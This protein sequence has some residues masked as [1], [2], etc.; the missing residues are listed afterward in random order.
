[1]QALAALSARRRAPKRRRR[2]GRPDRSHACASEFGPEPL[3]P[4]IVPTIVF[5]LAFGEP[6]AFHD[7]GGALGGD[8]P[9]YLIFWGSYFKS[10][11]TAT[12]EG[13]L[14]TSL[15]TSLAEQILGS[16]YFSG[17]SEYKGSPGRLYLAG[18]T[19][20]PS[21]NEAVSSTSIYNE[22][23][24][25]F[26]A[27]TIP[28]PDN[29]WPIYAVVTPPGYSDSADSDAGGW[30]QGVPDGFLSQSDVWISTSEPANGQQAAMDQ[31]STELSHELTEADTDPS[32]PAG[33]T[34]AQS[35]GVEVGPGALLPPSDD[36][37]QICDYE[38]EYHTYRLD[39]P[40]GPLVESHWSEALGT[41]IVSDGNSYQFDVSGGFLNK[42]G[43]SYHSTLT[44]NGGQAGANTA[45]TITISDA[46]NGE[47]TATLDG[48]TVWFDPTVITNIVVNTKSASTTV[49]LE[50]TWT[51]GTDVTINDGA[52]KP[53][54]I[55]VSPDAD[56]VNNFANGTVTVDDPDHKTVLTL[57]DQAETAYHTW[58]L[59]GWYFGLDS[60]V[61]VEYS[62]G[63]PGQVRLNA[64]TSDGTVDVNVSDCPTYI[65]LGGSSSSVVLSPAYRNLSLIEQPVFVSAFGPYNAMIF[66][67]QADPGSEDVTFEDGYVSENNMQPVVSSGS[68]QVI[69]YYAGSGNDSLSVAPS[70]EDMDDLVPIMAIYG[71]SGQDALTVNDKAHTYSNETANQYILSAG[72]AGGAIQRTYNEQIGGT[73]YHL[74]RTIGY[75][76][77][78]GGV[79]LDTDNA[80]TPVDVEGTI[81]S[82][83]INVGTGNTTVTVAATGQSLAAFAST[84]SLNGGTGT[85]SLV[86]DDQKD[87]YGSGSPYLV[88][89][90]FI[91][92][93]LPVSPYGTFI[94]YQGFSGSVTLDTDNN[95]TPVD[96]EGMSG[97]TTVNLGSG[98]T[99]VNVAEYGQS[100]AP[101]TFSSL[102]SMPLTLNGG[103]GADALI[104][105][106]Q[107][108]LAQSGTSEYMVTAGTISRTNKYIFL[109]FSFTATI[110]Y[111]NF[112]AGVTLNT[113]N[114]GT[115]VDVE[116]I[117]APTTVNVGSGNTTVNVAQNAQSLA[118]F[119]FSLLGSTP[120]TL[121]G[122]P[123]ADAL[124]VNDQQEPAQSGTSQYT[125]TTGT[126]SRTNKSYLS[127]FPYAATINYQ[128]FAAGVTLNTDDNGT[129]VDVEGTSAL[130]TVNVGTGNTAV[131]VTASGQ[132]LGLLGSNLTVAGGGATDSLTVYDS[133]NPLAA[134]SSGT[135]L[136]ATSTTYS[137][138]VNGQSISRTTNVS[139]RFLHFLT[140]RTIAYTGMTGGVTL[141]TDNNGT[142]V[143]VLATSVPTAVNLGKGNT[144]VTVAA[145]GENLGLLA[146]NLTVDGGSG[147]DSLIVY[148]SLDP[149]SATS[150]L[151]WAEWYSYTVSGQSV[152]RT[153]NYYS[154]LTFFQ[155]TLSVNYANMR[156]GVTLDT[157][158]NGTPVYVSGS[159]G[160]DP[161]T[162][163]G[164]TGTNTL[165][166][167]SV[168]TSWSLTG[169][170][171]GS[172]DGW[173]NF[174][175]FASLAGGS[176]AN[177]FDFSPG[178]SLSGSLSGG[179]GPNLLNYA[180]ESTSVTVDLAT[181][182]ATGVAGGVT[183]IQGVVGSTGSDTLT[184]S[185]SGPCLL[186][187]GG[188]AAKITGG[189][190]ASLLIGGGTTYDL[191][192][193]ALEA[194]LAE[195]DDTAIA[196]SQ[197]ITALTSGGGLNGSYVLTAATV[198]EDSSANTLTSGTGQTWFIVHA[199]D[200]VVNKKATNVVTEVP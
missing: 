122:G 102:A 114:N 110:D 14:A 105:N 51:S 79:T 91:Y 198:T 104:V 96:I 19:V 126:I 109:F 69:D 43:E 2:P 127:L 70:S 98:N 32:E 37:N 132:N 173:V 171:A 47:V 196:L 33:T 95:G 130:T 186:I 188:G 120:L 197:R 101:F 154:G 178:G 57:D 136:L 152:S 83:T 163:N 128:G 164:G 81:V 137:Y 92:R 94:S 155:S 74:V 62:I 64:G 30:N 150:G 88:Y 192:D 193:A 129:P 184:G 50:G 116:G 146:S 121:N 200:T 165:N 135:G 100:L 41:F 134:T 11:N 157:D 26:W 89:S 158:N 73:T 148:D 38:G 177:S 169:A 44:I 48:Q 115:P 61:P 24:N 36:G 39:G 90:G 139:N 191:N 194:I 7:G 68:F 159:P 118:P 76:D 35:Q 113:D 141:D 187:G 167:P 162:I 143:N 176:A 1:M 42:N 9:V 145:S 183:N 13:S 10:A 170:N 161:V 56:D 119:T 66:D 84:L 55:N 72:S 75:S 103:T 174:N 16:S 147:S 3:E 31:F 117:S 99:T 27:H 18:Y 142:P 17:L 151:G 29:N 8:T 168:A 5:N 179:A 153:S 25:T 181:G 185:S 22:T 138:T 4:R 190:S 107:Q 78:S 23:V 125:V 21:A 189:S 80:G 67:D 54:T 12:S 40:G 180:R 172:L 77:L 20:D 97:P 156:G 28:P 60:Q 52:G 133:L 199:R 195:W 112:S 65:N 45:D 87:P 82:T 140:S 71:G 49:N 111:H 58:S 63:S 131:S 93:T 182:A 6:S 34:V 85:D 166:G 144:L 108:E 15:Y 123:G 106:D 53:V 46:A 124:V 175:G 160:P 149:S 59:N 86:V